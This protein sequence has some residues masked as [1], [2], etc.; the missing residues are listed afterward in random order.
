V[1]IKQKSSREEEKKAREPAKIGYFNRPPRFFGGGIF[2]YNVCVK[3]RIFAVE[4]TPATETDETRILPP[5]PQQQSKRT[6]DTIN[7]NEVARMIHKLQYME[8]EL[9]FIKKIIL[10]GREKK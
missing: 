3:W 6:K 2:K 4:N 1:D 9:E 10:A 8:Q 7:P 5:M